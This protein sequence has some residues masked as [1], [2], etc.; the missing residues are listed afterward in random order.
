MQPWTMILSVIFVQASL[1][2]GNSVARLDTACSTPEVPQADDARLDTA[3]STPAVPQADDIDQ[4][5]VSLFQHSLV[6]GGS[7]DS[8]SASI[9]LQHASDRE[10]V[11]LTSETA[12]T[13][14]GEHRRGPDGP[15]EPLHSLSTHPFDMITRPHAGLRPDMISFGIYGKGCN[16]VDMHA[17]SFQVDSVILVQWSD[18][19]AASLVPPGVTSVTLSQENFQ[20]KLWLPNIAVTN[21]VPG[22]TGYDLIST[23]V[24]VNSSG[25]VTKID[26]SQSTI[27]NR[28][29]VQYFPWDSQVLAIN[30]ASTVYMLEDLK[31]VPITDP[32]VSGVNDDF[33]EGKGFDLLSHEILEF[34]ES[35]GPLRKSRGTLRISIRRDPS[36]YMYIIIL[37]LFFLLIMS[38][39]VF[40][41]PLV[42]HFAMP[43]LS[44]STVTFLS[45]ATLSLHLD[46]IMPPIAP[47]TWS[48]VFITTCQM[49]MC[50]AMFLNVVTEFIMHQLQLQRLADKIR[51][52]CRLLWPSLTFIAM[53]VC[54]LFKWAKP[55]ILF[56][57]IV[58]AICVV[59]IA[60]AAWCVLRT[61]QENTDGHDKSVPR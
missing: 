4:L 18:T 54:A 49:L 34:E 23:T 12:A 10:A 50:F 52:E 9:K 58:P 11:I 33:L 56:A 1:G 7:V 13:H 41:L 45:A 31:L 37:P 14:H 48:D 17:N 15:G 20:N 25:I 46:K 27:S 30:V 55:T 8:P 59:F 3:C 21:H 60:Y 39:V 6:L 24:T 19:R 43:R 36:S 38:W 28:Y 57:S 35:D 40:W 47:L 61:F 44:I 32:N 51:S 53:M 5:Q 29:N 16:N 2:V 42:P 26:R 22:S